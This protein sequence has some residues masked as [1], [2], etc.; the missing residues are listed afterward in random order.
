[1]ELHKHLNPCLT[2]ALAMGVLLPAGAVGA[3]EGIMRD[4]TQS[5]GPHVT[6][7]SGLE[8]NPIVVPL[9]VNGT[10]N[11]ADWDLPEGC[12]GY[13]H[14]NPDFTLMFGWTGEGLHFFFQGD[15]DTTLMVRRVGSR[16]AAYCNDDTAGDHLKVE[17]ETLRKES[18]GL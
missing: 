7:F 2:L 10:N 17:W 9:Q 13:I 4:T 12:T 1:M 18:G 8:P 5:R 11:A 14:S 3:Q 6:A 16:G 15:G